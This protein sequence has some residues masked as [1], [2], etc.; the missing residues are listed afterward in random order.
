MANEIKHTPGPWKQSSIIPSDEYTTVILGGQY[1]GIIA[2][3]ELSPYFEIEQS[4]ANAKLI[5]AAP[6]LLKA[7]QGVYSMLESD[8]EASEF[9]DMGKI[10]SAINKATL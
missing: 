10:K 6:E 1:N 8:P 7:L 4:E 3:A 5:A 9:Y 2:R